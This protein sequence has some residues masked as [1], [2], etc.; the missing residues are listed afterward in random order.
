[1]KRWSRLT[2]A[3]D[4]EVFVERIPFVETRDYVRIVMRN[5]DMYR[6]LYE[7]APAN[8]PAPAAQ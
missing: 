8:P 1:V 6:A 3:S 4:P 2:G 7:F 5:A